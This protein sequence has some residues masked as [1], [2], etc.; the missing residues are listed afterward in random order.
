MLHIVPSNSSQKSN[1]FFLVPSSRKNV[2]NF[3]KIFKFY[4]F[5]LL[6]NSHHHPPTV[7][8]KFSPFLYFVCGWLPL[9]EC[10]S[11]IDF[12]V[13]RRGAMRQ[14]H[15]TWFKVSH[16][17]WWISFV[18]VAFRNDSKGALLRNRETWGPCKTYTPW[19]TPYIAILAVVVFR[20][21]LSSPSPTFCYLQILRELSL[22]WRFSSSRT[23][24]CVVGHLLI[25]LVSSDPKH[26]SNIIRQSPCFFLFSSSRDRGERKGGGRVVASLVSI[27]K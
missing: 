10:P 18:R 20:F 14:Q 7:L 19:T 23:T 2:N 5:F 13:M 17:P 4:F 22:C 12:D 9:F 3:Q 27:L 6:H 16:F 15:C 21:S 8:K 26:T 24:E 1:F 25:S 11:E